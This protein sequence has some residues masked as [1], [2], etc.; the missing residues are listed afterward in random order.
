M[1]DE[2]CIHYIAPEKCVSREL[3]ASKDR[4]EQAISFDASGNIKVAR[5]ALDL[6]CDTSG[7]LKLK[8]GVDSSISCNASNWFGFF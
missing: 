2:N 6:K 8:T 3:E 4:Q 1:V 5:K 7:E